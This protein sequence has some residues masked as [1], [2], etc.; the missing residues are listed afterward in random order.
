M[1]VQD[2]YSV[3]VT[4]NMVVPGEHFYPSEENSLFFQLHEILRY[5]AVIK[6]IFLLSMSR[7]LSC[8]QMEN[9]NTSEE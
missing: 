4:G 8:S 1:I 5:K 9:L 3:F 2:S 7:C 6:M